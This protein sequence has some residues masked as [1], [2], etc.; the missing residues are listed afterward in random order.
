MIPLSGCQP[1]DSEQVYDIKVE[2]SMA[3]SLS[4]VCVRAFAFCIADAILQRSEQ[5]IPY[6]VLTID[7]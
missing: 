6:I 7:S 4:R 1:I 3:C 5:Y 2:S